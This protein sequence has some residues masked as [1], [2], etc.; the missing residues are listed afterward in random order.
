MP[1]NPEVKKVI[2]MIEERIA[3]LSTMRTMLIRE[4]GV[5]E[6][7]VPNFVRTKFPVRSESPVSHAPIISESPSVS[8]SPSASPS[9]GPTT[10]KEALV[11]FLLENGPHSRKELAEKTSIPVGTIAFLLNDKETFEHVQG[12]K[13]KVREVPSS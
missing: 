3:S 10:R 13:W 6:E 9:P 4:F 1:A 8:S 2:Q 5:E 12:N 7:T 11:Q